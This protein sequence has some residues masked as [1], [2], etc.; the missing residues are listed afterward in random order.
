MPGAG[1]RR[2]VTL[3]QLW[4][5]GGRVVSPERLSGGLGSHMLESLLDSI[6]SIACERDGAA[7]GDPLS[8]TEETRDQIAGVYG[9]RVVRWGVLLRY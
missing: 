8:R 2:P 7:G 9:C 3:G 1:A 5:G 6:C 4:A